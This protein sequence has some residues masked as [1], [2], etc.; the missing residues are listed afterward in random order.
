MTTPR[1]S[2]LLMPAG[3]LEKLKVAVL[4]GADAVYLGTPDMSLRTKSKFSLEDIKAGVEFAHARGVRVYMTLNLFTHNKDI[5]KLHDYIEVLRDV[6]PDG[7]IVADTGV[8]QMLRR[9]AP[10]LSLHISTQANVCSWL[11]V[12]FWKEAGAE[13]IVLAREV[14]F[15]EM[16]EIREKCPDIRLESFVHGAMCMTYSGRCL[17]SNF[18]AERGANQGNCANSCRWHYKVHMRL[19]DGTLKEIEVNESNIGLFEFVLEEGV[20][21]GEFMPIEEDQRGAYILNS[22]DMCLMPKLDDLLRI[23]IDS[24]KVEGRGK[25]PYYVATVARAYRRAIDA[26]YRDADNWS[27]EPFM[28]ELEA[29]TS[30]GYTIAFHEGRLQNFAHSYDHTTAIAP[31]E[32]AGMVVETRADG[33]V[34]AV[35]NQLAAGEVMEFLP[36]DPSAEPV[37]LRLYEFWLESGEG[38][39]VAVFGARADRIF[40]PY[41]AFDR[42]SPESVQRRFP[43]YTILRKESVLGAD[44]WQ[45]LKL[46]RTAQRIELGAGERTPAYTRQVAQLQALIGQDMMDKRAR[47][48]RK[49][50]EGCCG[51]GCN[52]CLMFWNDPAYAKAR[53]LLALKKHGELLDR[54]MRERASEG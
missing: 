10:E 54:D 30:R 9:A 3:S 25:S 18:M 35:K 2:E 6:R 46:D 38:P 29:A 32:F 21:P 47:S 15:A 28:R 22:K 39:Y 42:E 19:K 17:L 49:G 43:P 4:Y 31:W 8:F 20:R 13:L 27:P 26:W 52:G 7:V 53:D 12:D 23:G 34:I 44:D 1:R 37:L 11:T 40:I 48:S 14:T 41:S 50:V 33:L 5:E 24:L 36:P 51:R 16:A 45:R